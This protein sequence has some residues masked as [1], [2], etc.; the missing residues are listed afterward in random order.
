MKPSWFAAIKST[1][2]PTTCTKS[3]WKK[4]K[5]LEPLLWLGAPLGS[6]SSLMHPSGHWPQANSYVVA[7]LPSKASSLR[8]NMPGRSAHPLKT[9]VYDGRCEQNFILTPRGA[10]SAAGF[11][12]GYGRGLN[13]LFHSSVLPTLEEALWFLK[14]D[15]IHQT[16]FTFKNGAAV[17][18]EHS[19]CSQQGV[20]WLQRWKRSLVA[21]W[22]RAQHTDLHP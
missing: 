15:D 19:S 6:S 3:F 2:E 7:D 16:T 5:I 14:L 18:S 22:Q 21:W 9:A 17:L 4:V 10:L 8:G 1:E 12:V 13:F 20:T 11:P